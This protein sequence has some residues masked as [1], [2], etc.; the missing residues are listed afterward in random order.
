MNVSNPDVAYPVIFIVWLI[1]WVLPSLL[2]GNLWKNKGH[3]GAGG[4]WLS[5][6]FTPVLGLIIGLVFSNANAKPTIVYI[7]KETQEQQPKI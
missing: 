5:F 1:V 7:Q 3:S 4:F 2:V 6:F